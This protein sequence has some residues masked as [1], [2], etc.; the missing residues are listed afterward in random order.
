MRLKVF[1]I[2]GVSLGNGYH[3]TSLKMENTLSIIP[4]ILFIISAILGI[5]DNSVSIFNKY[6][7]PIK[8]K[9]GYAISIKEIRQNIKNSANL[10][11]NSELRKCLKLRRLYFTVLILCFLSVIVVSFFNSY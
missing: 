8:K 6:N 5:M 7:L 11:M 10:T 4:I 3:S 1:T 2:F 9:S